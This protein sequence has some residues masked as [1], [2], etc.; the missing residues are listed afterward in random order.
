MLIVKSFCLLLTA[1]VLVGCSTSPTQFLDS[2]S[3]LVSPG[4]V[5]SATGKLVQSA[6]QPSHETASPNKAAANKSLQWHD[7]F[8]QAQQQSIATGKPILVGFLGSDWCPPCIKLK[9][10]VF[11]SQEFKNWASNKVVLLELDY[12]KHKPQPQNIRIQNQQLAQKY[13][14]Q[15]YPTVLFLNSKGEPLGKLGYAPN[16]TDWLASANKILR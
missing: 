15:G 8:E 13:A 7:S 5:T 9:K 10:S 12:P 11:Q 14:I 2:S 3:R 6:A 16:A 4:T 1:S